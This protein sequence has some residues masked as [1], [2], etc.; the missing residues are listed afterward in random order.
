MKPDPASPSTAVIELADLVVE[1]GGRTVLELPQLRVEAGE[2][3]ALVGPNGA[4][5]STLLR[6]LSGFVTP[7]RGSVRVLGRE[8]AGPRGSRLQGAELRALR[9]E[10]GQ[11]LQGLHL[12]PRLTARENVLIGALARVPGWRSWAR[13]YPP[14]LQREADA[15]L[16]AVGLLE[17]AD[18]RIDRLSGGERQKIGMARM[19][20]QRARLILADEPTAHLDPNACADACA[21][22]V[23]AARGATLLT[24]VHHRTLLP[25]LADR[26]LGLQQGRL[27][28]DCELHTLSEHSLTEA[29]ASLYRAQAPIDHPARALSPSVTRTD[30]L[31]PAIGDAP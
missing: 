31:Q 6:V 21:G 8:L 7:A 19:R 29:L 2:R 18:E 3:V 9:A 13:W 14:A 27:V 4:G 20:L 10:I 22:L 16:A 17:R 1:V 26:V 11:V 28:L 12:V 25:L 23:E 5:K 30:H 15:A 24:V